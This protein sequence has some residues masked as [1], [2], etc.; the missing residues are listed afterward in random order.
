MHQKLSQM[1][2]FLKRIP[3]AVSSVRFA[4]QIKSSLVSAICRLYLSRLKSMYW[5]RHH[6]DE[7]DSTYALSNHANE[8]YV[9][10]TTDKI[11]GRLLYSRGYFD[12]QKFERAMQIIDTE[13]GGRKPQLLFDVGANIGPICIPAVT[14]GY[15]KR[16]IAFEPDPQNF[17]LLRINTILN[18]VEN[19]IECHEIALGAENG[20]AQLSLNA[21]NHGDHKIFTGQENSS[22]QTISV[23]VHRF[24]DFLPDDENIE[25]IIWIDVQGFEADVLSGA[26]KSLGKVWPLVF[27]FT[28]QDLKANGTFEHLINF[29]SES[30]Y[31]KYCDLESRSIFLTP[32]T[33]K[34]LFEL[35]LSLEKNNA[36]TDILLL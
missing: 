27:E 18:D 33:Q 20:I 21:E 29:I 12:F 7:L 6:F 14:R 15:V 16:A 13:R 35:A 26:T 8:N 25:G 9:V 30:G 34:N 32:I 5:R 10:Q 28:P 31:S 4:R 24:D 17:R 2:E 22:A 19:L 36:F 23:P 3:G 11:I 1:R